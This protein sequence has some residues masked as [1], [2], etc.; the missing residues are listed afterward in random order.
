MV[1]S[2]L[3]TVVAIW[4]WQVN[5]LLHLTGNFSKSINHHPNKERWLVHK[6]KDVESLWLINFLLN[7]IY[8]CWDP[9]ISSTKKKWKE[10]VKNPFWRC[11]FHKKTQASSIAY[12]HDTWSSWSLIKP[13]K[14]EQLTDITFFGFR[15]QETSKKNEAYTT[16]LF[17]LLLGQF[18]HKA[19]CTVHCKKV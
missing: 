5:F 9:I 2:L 3:S 16:I 18:R 4:K 10:N 8:W 17:G 15:L 6:L 1:Q 14:I 7:L 19:L 12:R 13:L 11:K